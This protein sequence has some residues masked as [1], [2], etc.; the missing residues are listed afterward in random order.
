MSSFGLSSFKKKRQGKHI[1]VS[2]VERL[3]DDGRLENCVC[4]DCEQQ[5]PNETTEKV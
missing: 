2:L 3:R 1:G 5:I 4:S